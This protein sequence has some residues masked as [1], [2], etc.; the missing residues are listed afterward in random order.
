MF[1]QNGQYFADDIFKWILLNEKFEISFNLSLKFVRE[2]AIDNNWLRQRF[3][4]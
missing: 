1:E 3:G 2:G 4:A